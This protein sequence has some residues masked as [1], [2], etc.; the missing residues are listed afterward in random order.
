MVLLENLDCNNSLDATIIHQ[1][2]S[3]E[4]YSFLIEVGYQSCNYD[5]SFIRLTSQ[6][7]QKVYCE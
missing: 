2:Q 7:L 3:K 6:G 4:L 5:G 1:V